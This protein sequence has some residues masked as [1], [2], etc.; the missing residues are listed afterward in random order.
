MT[1]FE[2]E[3]EF[4]QC[5]ANPMYLN[6]LA[7]SKVLEE[8]AFLEYLKYLEYWRAPEYT[9]LNVKVSRVPVLPVAA[10]RASIQGATAASRVCGEVARGC[11]AGVARTS[12][13]VILT[14]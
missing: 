12:Y 6:Y 11:G 14:A 9:R 1:R 8:E 13:H 4:V 7:Q 10:A 5:L 2:R 3:L